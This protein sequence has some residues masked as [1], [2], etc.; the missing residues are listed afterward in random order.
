MNASKAGGNTGTP[1]RDESWVNREYGREKWPAVMERINAEIAGGERSLSRLVAKV[2][3]WEAESPALQPVTAVALGE[4]LTLPASLAW[5][6]FYALAAEA[7]IA[8]CRDDTGAV[9]DLGC[10]WG[11]SLFDI[12]LRGGPRAAGYHALEFT[13]AGVDCVNLLAS[14]EPRITVV[15]ARFDFR[16][17]DFSSLPRGLAHAAVFTISS[18]HQVP[19]LDKDA[20]RAILTIADSVDCLHF[21]QIGWQ[22]NPGARAAAD[23]DYA[24][25]ND[26]NRNLWDVLT[27][28]KENREIEIVDVR[29][30][31][32]GMQALYPI[33]L[34]HWRSRRA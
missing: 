22:I 17:P 10:G 14:L 4:R 12:W 1:V 3:R 26:Y 34:V 6:G 19:T 23:R 28:L 30:D 21:E 2:A 15:A 11:R 24:V 32:F 27:G 5:H 31:L 8:A 7:V 13:Q 25:R 29:A 9:V 33:S 18:V 16:N 20:F